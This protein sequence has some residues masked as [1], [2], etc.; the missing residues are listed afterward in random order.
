MHN[1]SVICFL[2]TKADSTSDAL[3]FLKHFGFD[4]EY[5]VPSQG[6]AGGLWLFWRSSSVSLDILQS[7]SQ[8][9]HCSLSHQQVT[10]FATFI[11]AQP[12]AA[13]KELFWSDMGN[14]A[15]N[16]EDS[17]VVLGDFNDILT[18]D[19][20]SPKAMR[21]FVRTQR[22]RERLESC[23]LHSTEPLGCKFTWFRKQGGRVLL[24]ERLDRALFNFR[25]LEDLPDAKVINLPRLYSDHHPIL[26]CLDAPPS[27]R[28]QN[29]PTRFEAAWLT[30]ESFKSVFT[31]AWM[32]ASSSITTAINSVQK[33][34]LQWNRNVFGNLFHRKRH[35]RGRLE[36]IQNSIHYHNSQFLQNL[37]IQLLQEYHQVLHAE[38]LFWC[39]KSRADW[40]ASGDRNT[41][42]YHASTI[43]RR[44]RNQISALKVDGEWM[45]ESKGLKRHIHDFYLGLF[46]RK[47]TQPLIKDYSAYQPQLSDEDGASLLIPVSLEEVRTA[48]FSMKGLKSPGPNG[49]QPF[50]Y[51]KH[52]EVV[53][54]T[55]LSFV[56]N[57]LRDGYFEHTLLQAHITLIP[58]GDCP[59]IIQKFRPICLLNVA[60]K[61][62]S[63]VI[64]N[65]L[66]PFLQH[67]IGP[68]QNSFLAGR[69]TTNNIILTQEVVHS[70]RKK[71]GRKGAIVF[72]IDLHKAFDSID[73][74]FLTR[75][76]QDFNIPAPLIRL[77]MFSVTSLQLSILWN[78][79]ALP[80]FQ[81]QRG[82]RQGDPLSPYLFIMVMEKLS[83]MI[84]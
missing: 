38:E 27:I 81:P 41:S 71:R 50:F 10:C 13:M 7:S 22:F 76:L 8:F 66:R 17:W 58:K 68:F 73:W 32:A 74:G 79:E 35:L 59:D 5:Q 64:V 84:Q 1:P 6:M 31:Q 82:L 28:T 75:V 63:K 36:G 67:L 23:G 26:L 37:E 42:F 61:V 45:M 34:C 40:I 77:I 16:M 56:N 14:L 3:R 72:K 11:Y 78:G 12:H 47:D 4:K 54:G 24:R 52:W 53:S 70:M 65:R 2:E 9:I 30:Y 21:G 44:R 48:L 60:Y 39:Q 29:K 62:L 80:S 43:V 57:A 19:E 15:Q 20:A 83:H 55:L 25:A 51:Q 33:A 46:M 69:S 49:I 18:V